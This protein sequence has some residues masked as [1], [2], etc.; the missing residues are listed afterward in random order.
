MS[1]LRHIKRMEFI[2]FLIRRKATGNLQ[3]FACKNRLSKNG[4]LQVLKEMKEIGFPIKYSRYINSYYYEKEGQMVK[5]MFIEEGTM[6]T[7][8]EMKN[9]MGSNTDNLCFSETTTFEKCQ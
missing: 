9:I 4:L 5:K 1:I 2:D 6:L 7:R 8:E 3:V